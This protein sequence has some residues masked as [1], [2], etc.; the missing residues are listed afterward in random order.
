MA[1]IAEKL[2]PPVIAGSIPAFY[3][4]NGT[5]IVAVPFSMNKAVGYNDIAGFKLKIKT[6]Q[7]NTYL[8]TLSAQKTGDD[9]TDRIVHFQWR[10]QD[11]GFNKIKIGQFLK[12]QLAYYDEN[13]TIGYYSTVG[14]IK[15]T[16][17]PSVSFVLN[18]SNQTQFQGT[19]YGKYETGLDKSE[20]PYSYI[21]SLYDRW[22][23]TLIETSGWRLHNSTIKN[24]NEDDLS[25]SYDS[26]TF[27][28]P[29]IKNQIYY[30]QYGVKTI[31][32][33]EIYTPLL[34][35]M[36][37]DTGI[38]DIHSILYAEN[39]FD[40]GYI[41][42][43]FDENSFQDREDFN[44]AISIEVSR[45]EK[46]DGYNS[47][48][49]IKKVYFSNLQKVLDW[50]FKDFTIEQGMWYKYSFR[51]YD[52]NGN[53]TTLCVAKDIQTGKEEIFADFEDMF[54]WDGERQLKIRLN[55]K[56][57]SFKTTLLESKIDTIGSR[58]PFIFRN[59]SVAY[60]EFPISGLI[61]YLTDENSLFLNHITDLDIYMA[62]TLVRDG[63]PS[64]ETQ[65][66]QTSTINLA[67]YNIS[68]ERKFKIKVLDWLNNGKI[69]LFRSPTEGNYLVRL[70]NVSLSPE[71]KLSRMLH[72]FSA[73][74]YEMEEFSY[75]NLLELGIIKIEEIEEEKIYTESV[76]LAKLIRQN[77]NKIEA[78][79]SIKVNVYQIINFLSLK[80][81]S[82]NSYPNF[83][84][85]LGEDTAEQRT[86]IL[87][88]EF[89]LQS[90]NDILPDVY[91][92]GGDNTLNYNSEDEHPVPIFWERMVDLVGDAL[93]TYQYKSNEVL[94]GQ[95]STENDK[96][97]DTVSIENIVETII[98][99]TPK[100]FYKE[101]ENMAES[102]LQLFVLNFRRKTEMPKP[103]QN[104]NVAYLDK[105]CLYYTEE[106]NNKIYYMLNDEGTQLEQVTLDETDN[107]IILIDEN[108]L[109]YYFNTIPVISFTN[110]LYKE[111]KLGRWYCADCAYQ[112]KKVTYKEE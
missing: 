107:Q 26:Y 50:S 102:L 23:K 69:K 68:A 41:K 61:S 13:E 34:S 11:E 86:K 28:T 18:E 83:Y 65:Y 27:E 48:R 72:T 82:G 66:L 97:I 3:S 46:T 44:R 29:L 2:Y 38:T 81:T 96:I 45:A 111:I 63:S 10:E 43:F 106:N 7:S 36:D 92:N 58:Y 94:A 16:S 52:E 108:N 80:T 87:T 55:P 74:A 73:T 47:W 37:T 84:V 33:L 9:L 112:I 17:K 75:K 90:K 53:H 25:S 12:V 77:A 78:G 21:F 93:L 31:N 4:D 103:A 110:R 109:S 100:V 79:E 91:F 70:L 89:I 24:S 32:N 105:S 88:R 15:Y 85:R 5:A 54:L 49:V 59:G 67:G 57:A 62:D 22:E 104:F 30:I 8:T 51:Q 99:P 56:V 76:S 14:T 60:K 71:D 35:C 40:D 6:A 19:Y 64:D 20:R 95:I 42:L 39:M 98:G 101:N 1:G